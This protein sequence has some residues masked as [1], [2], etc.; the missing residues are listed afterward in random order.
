[1]SSELRAIHVLNERLR[2]D[3]SKARTTLGDRIT[4]VKQEI[5]RRYTR[6]HYTSIM[7]FTI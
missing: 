1:M 6:V 5:T 4:A 7:L 3:E 2:S